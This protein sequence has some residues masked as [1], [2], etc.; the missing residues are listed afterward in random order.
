MRDR[1]KAFEHEVLNLCV[2]LLWIIPQRRDKL[3][4]CGEPDV[5]SDVSTTSDPDSYRDLCTQWMTAVGVES[6]WMAV[7]HDGTSSRRV[8]LKLKIW[9]L[10]WRKLFTCI[11][12]FPRPPTGSLRVLKTAVGVIPTLHCDVSRD[13][14]RGLCTQWMTSV[15]VESHW[16]ATFPQPPIPVPIAIGIGIILRTEERCR[17]GQLIFEKM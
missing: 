7:V 5:H 8:V 3:C 9:F 1:R 4:L 14:R 15:G 16:V 12:T 17:G 6:H 11:P 10:D 2:S 13:R